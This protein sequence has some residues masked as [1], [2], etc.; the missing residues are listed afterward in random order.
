MWTVGGIFILFFRFYSVHEAGDSGPQIFDTCDSTALEEVHTQFL[1]LLH[2]HSRR[3]ARQR[4][5]G[6]KV[7][8][9]WHQQMRA[10]VCVFVGGGGGNRGAAGQPRLFVP[11]VLVLVFNRW[12]G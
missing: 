11:V 8:R 12:N 5:E 10:M 6:R 7:F 4:T 9:K 3:Q 2:A 1:L